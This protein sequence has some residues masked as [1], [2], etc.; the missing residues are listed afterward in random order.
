MKPATSYADDD[1]PA[2]A[3]QT[4]AQKAAMDSMSSSKQTSIII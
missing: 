1:G 2:T 3:R 4:R